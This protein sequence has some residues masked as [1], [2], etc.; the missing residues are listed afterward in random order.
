MMVIASSKR[1]RS[2]S[3]LTL[4]NV[5]VNMTLCAGT[6]GAGCATNP[7]TAIDTSIPAVGEANK[8]AP[9]YDEVAQRWNT[10]TNDLSRIWARA[11]VQIRYVDADGKRHNEQGEGH[12]QLVQPSDFALSIGKLGEV[13]LWLGSDA[14]RYWL[15][16][17][18]D[19]SHASVGAHATLGMACHKSLG[20]PAHPLDMLDLM[21]VTALPTLAGAQAAG[22]EAPW[23][24]LTRDAQLL[25]VEA[26]A[27]FGRRR[28][29]LDPVTLLPRRIQLFPS[30]QV[31]PGD[32]PA[33]SADLTNPAPVKLR[34]RGGFFPRVASRIEIDHPA[35]D[36]HIVL[37]LTDLSD[38]RDQAGRL[39]PRVFDF[40]SLT[41]AFAVSDIEQ[42]DADC[43]QFA[44]PYDNGSDGS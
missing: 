20:L 25:V 27:R 32:A 14:S 24:T 12:L 31:S 39:S 17:P 42:L 44:A 33:I 37:H 43:D 35:S 7:S 5:L 41:S 19:A 15:I 3:R 4:R 23:V 36:T 11:V 8:K 18:G 38:G 28:M 10:R 16:E 6:L 13:L 21:G 30:V 1:L 9:S 40:N 2:R 22:R 26:P 29:F 34:T